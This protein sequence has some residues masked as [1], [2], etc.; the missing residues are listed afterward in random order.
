MAE[1]KNPFDFGTGSIDKD[2]WLRDI[3]A[4]Q[5]DFVS[6]YSSA[7]NKHKAALMRE[8]FT[9]LRRRI[10]NGDMLNRTADGQY[11]FS[12]ALNR[13]DKHMQEA[14]QRALGFMGDLARRQI[15]APPAAEPEKK[16]LGNL[17]ER[18]IKSLNP[19]G[20]FNTE[21]YW[22]NQTDEERRIALKDFLNKEL[23]EAG[24]YQDF[25]NF[26]DKDTYTQR[27]Q[28]VMNLLESGK[29]NDWSLQQL[30]FTKNWLQ[31]PTD[32]EETE[33]PKSELE[34]ANERLQAATEAQQ[35]QQINQQVA[36]LTAPS[37]T[38]QALL[39]FNPSDYWSYD[40]FTRDRNKRIEALKYTDENG[41]EFLKANSILR[42]TPTGNGHFTNQVTTRNTA[43]NG[44]AA[45]DARTYAQ[46]QYAQEISSRLNDY[47]KNLGVNYQS[48]L[49]NDKRGLMTNL[50]QLF[51]QDPDNKY[52][53]EDVVNNLFA[54]QQ[55]GKYG[56][57]GSTLSYDPSTHTLYNGN[58]ID[59]YKEGGILKGQNGLIVD[60]SYYV[61]PSKPSKEQKTEATSDK[62]KQQF[63]TAENA[64]IAATI[65][66][67]ASM[68][69]AFI[70][71]YGT[72]ASAVLGLGSTATNFGAD[73]A[74]G[75]GLWDATKNAG[76]GLA[77]DVM[78][79]IPGL[80]GVGKG[81]KIARNLMW[82]VPKMMQWVN[83]YQGM[84]NAGE[85][86]NSIMKL[87]SPS[88]MTV[89][90]WQ[91]VSQALQI[92]TGHGRS[93]ATKI[94]KAGMSKTTTTTEPEH[95][96]FTNKGKQK[97]SDETFK[98]LREARGTKAR[99]ALTQ[100]LMGEGVTLQQTRFAPWNTSTRFGAFKE[101]P[102][103]TKV[104][105]QNK[106]KNWFSDENLVEKAENFNPSVD[107]RSIIS[108]IN[109]YRTY[110]NNRVPKSSPLPEY[111][112]RP[113]DILPQ[114]FGMTK[115][116]MA[117]GGFDMDKPKRKP[118][119]EEQKATRRQKAAAKKQEQKA[120]E[121]EN[122]RR[123]QM[124]GMSEEIPQASSQT[125]NIQR[126][127][128]YANLNSRFANE[129]EMPGPQMETQKNK[130]YRRYGNAVRGHQI[131]GILKALRN[132]GIIKAKWGDDTSDWMTP[133]YNPEK[134][135]AIYTNPYFPNIKYN[136]TAPWYK[137][138]FSGESVVNLGSD[139]SGRADLPG[140]LTGNNL[141][142]AFARNQAY[143][144]SGQQN[145]QADIQGYFDQLPSPV[146]ANN[147]QGLT[148]IYNKAIDELYLPFISGKNVPDYLKT[149]AT[150]HNLLFR[151]VY[152]SRAKVNGGDDNYDIGWNPDIIKTFGSASFARR[153]V[154]YETKW[155]DDLKNNL[156]QA[157][158]RVSKI[159][160]NGIEGYVYTDENG[161]IHPLT[162]DQLK[163]INGQQAPQKQEKESSKA[164]DSEGGI[165]TIFNTEYKNPNDP[166]PYIIA[167][168]TIRGLTGNRNIYKN[169]ADETPQASLN[170]PIDRKLAIVG[171]QEAIKQGQNQLTDLRNA[172]WMQ[173]SSDQQTNLAGMYET[174]GKGRDIMNGQFMKDSGRQ[175]E[176]A[177][178]SW[179]LD[180]EDTL[181]N[182]GVGDA[183]RKAIA[184]RARM[185]AQIRAAWRSGDNNIL[186]GALSDTG[187]W[188]LKRY[189]REQDIVD[190][191]KELSLGT[192]EEYAQAALSND[193][194]YSRIMNKHAAGQTLTNEEKAY[195][196]RMQAEALKGIRSK[197]ASSYYNTYHTPGFGGGLYTT[198]AKDGT[199]LEVAKLRARS[200]DNDRYVSM[201]KD[202]RTTRSRRRRRR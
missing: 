78:G 81:A 192:P 154:N 169:L 58:N 83:T 166:T 138:R 75:Q 134:Q 193:A 180:N 10:A 130:F 50:A 168:K 13:E 135:E 111:L 137:S 173:H 196:R 118:L 98:R 85:I 186:M 156:A 126:K 57:R 113:V 24:N 100:E 11:Q 171:W 189:Q 181:Y 31:Q 110:Y 89:Q 9:D 176:T 79:L 68:G 52:V 67:I 178:K 19:S 182:L 121:L 155:E 39:T 133:Q 34:Q 147:L 175:F 116:G 54:K 109:P 153:P 25:G 7:V 4:E 185:M 84:Q 74:D 12:S 91:N 202:L 187:N 142:Y 144:K 162:N 30:G 139:D 69:A 95:Y 117:A 46:S 33:T 65:A 108:K 96:I 90:D 149:D 140:G 179:N 45:K 51:T 105:V 102:G 3:D 115:S 28:T 101:I 195:V 129:V 17:E 42:R 37:P 145:K 150:K 21:A 86:K 123:Q 93:V 40:S 59:A 41:N 18:Y 161:R 170:D 164:T 152:R 22:K 14:Y 23:K 48:I 94:K 200:K 8:A 141:D 62:S 99:Q 87:T 2:Q 38:Y 44:Q 148:D 165:K 122:L 55:D 92:M 159:S 158:D 47:F 157:K 172:T 132:G 1:P 43:W 163:L 124:Y 82:A 128:E 26:G 146:D 184:D 183:N 64:R 66:D 49:N 190:K 56:L 197:F 104:E 88:S 160:H 167:G 127:Q 194:E 119:T 63:S 71:G 32:Q 201:I 136:G 199:K 151:Q 70:P 198:I 103:K 120:K 29:A 76:F 191:A 125:I 97:V 15:Q 143:V 77:A 20:K 114:G 106:H 5:G 188:M 60:D 73:L 131:G 36:A 35:V 6:Q 177:Q 72:A 112:K 80:G 107:I 27:L 16:A 174:E 61:T 53:M